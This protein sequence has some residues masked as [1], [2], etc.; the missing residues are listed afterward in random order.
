[1]RSFHTK[2]R[3]IKNSLPTPFDPTLNIVVQPIETVSEHQA[4][5]RDGKDLLVTQLS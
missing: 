5:L 2:S 1:M 3:M 4:T